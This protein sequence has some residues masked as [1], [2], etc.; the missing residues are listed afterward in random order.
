MNA[1][2]AGRPRDEHRERGVSADAGPTSPAPHLDEI[3]QRIVAILQVDGRRRFAAIAEEIG[4][5]EGTVRRRVQR[6]L[7]SSL[8]QIVG[9]SD[10][11]RLGF[12]AMALVALRVAPKLVEAVAKEMAALPETSYV[13]STTGRFDIVAEVICR[14]MPAFK[15]VLS[16]IHSIDGVTSVEASMLLQIHKLAYGWGVGEVE[17]A[18]PVR[19]SHPS[20]DGVAQAGPDLASR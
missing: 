5:S 9:I 10:P 14:D 8:L 17:V 1:E 18:P 3:D 16:R 11:L 4:V 6:L 2:T 12:G 13:A 15:R 19:G 7:D 20:P